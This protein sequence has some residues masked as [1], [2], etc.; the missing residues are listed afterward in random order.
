MNYMQFGSFYKNVGGGYDE[1]DVR[2]A[3]DVY[4]NII[5]LLKKSTSKDERTSIDELTKIISEFPKGFGFK[6]T[7]YTSTGRDMY[8]KKIPYIYYSIIT[9]KGKIIMNSYKHLYDIRDIAFTIVHSKNQR[10]LEMDNLVYMY[11][12]EYDR[13]NIVEIK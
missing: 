5:T 11:G 12:D 6:F 4:K 2:R 13:K 1:K 10:K 8:E 7:L 9:S 3:K